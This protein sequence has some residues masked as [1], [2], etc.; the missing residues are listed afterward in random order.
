MPARMPATRPQ[1]ARTLREI[2]LATWNPTADGGDLGRSV[3]ERWQ[4]VLD[5]LDR[6]PGRTLDTI[7]RAVREQATEADMAADPAVRVA[8]DVGDAVSAWDHNPGNALTGLGDALAPLGELLNPGG[9]PALV[10]LL[11]RDEF[12]DHGGLCPWWVNPADPVVETAAGPIHQACV[13]RHLRTAWQHLADVLVPLTADRHPTSATAAII[14]VLTVA[15]DA[16]DSVA[17]KLAAV[18]ATRLRQ[19]R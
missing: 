10:C 5:T 15:A 8:R 18:R 7:A 4:H 6:E 12:G 17:P 2:I 9:S 13:T 11:G 14:E 19:P 1:A 3:D 16:L